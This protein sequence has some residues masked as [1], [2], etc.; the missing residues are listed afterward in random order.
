[1]QR[2]AGKTAKGVGGSIAPCYNRAVAQFDMAAVAVL[3]VFAY[4]GYRRG[5]M[6]FV[7]SLTG[8][9]LAFA[10]A[11]VVAPLL[12]PYV[13][14]YLRV[15]LFVAQPVAVVGLTAALRLVFGVAVR[16]LAGALR[17][18]VHAIPP[19]KMLD[20][21]LGIVPG[22]A[23]GAAFVLAVMVAT[24]SL[25]LGRATHDAAA[26]SWV[27]RTIVTRPEDAMAT[28]R[29]LWDQIVVAPPR[30][31]ALP[32]A[33]G[34]GGL[35]LGAFAAY[36]MRAGRGEMRAEQ[37]LREAPTVRTP[38]AAVNV[39]RAADPLALPRTALGVLVAA[40]MVAALLGVS[41]R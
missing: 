1:M 28:G 20:Q 14:R 7:L 2:R 15:P 13:A 37:E 23:L 32:L 8:G 25:P 11:A 38:R 16:E 41:L 27:A 33:L 26:S 24:L 12:A 5:L 3:A 31:S 9:L 36:R 22:L 29:R 34:V 17:S 10:L 35:W 19:L 6:G 21:V 4:G 18:L 39:A 40:A 30:L